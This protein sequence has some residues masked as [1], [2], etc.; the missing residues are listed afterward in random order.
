LHKE[1]LEETLVFIK[2]PDSVLD[3]IQKDRMDRILRKYREDFESV[4]T[5]YK[6]I[7]IDEKSGIKAQMHQITEKLEESFLL[8]YVELFN[9]IS[10][11][12]EFNERLMSIVTVIMIFILLIA[13]PRINY[14]IMNIITDFRLGLMD[15]FEYLNKQRDDTHHIKIRAKGEIANMA[16]MVNNQIDKIQDDIEKD[17]ELIKDTTQVAKQVS[18]GSISI[19]ISKSSNNEALNELKDVFNYMLESLENNIAQILHVV[20]TYSEHDY[21]KRVKNNNLQ[22]EMA[23]LVEGINTLGD[24]VSRMLVHNKQNG[25]VLGNSANELTNSVSKLSASVKHQADSFNSTSIAVEQITSSLHSTYS[26][27][28]QMYKISEDTKTN[29]QDGQRLTKE[30]V[31]AMDGINDSTNN[32]KVAIE[33][34]NQIAFQTNILSLNAAVEAATAGEAGKGFAVVAQEVRNLANRSADVA[35]EIKTLVDSA[36]LQAENG[37]KIAD[38]MLEG[39]EILYNNISTTTTLIEDVTKS[40]KEQLGAINKINDT[41]IE[42]DTATQDDAKVAMVTDKVAKDTSEI[43]KLIIFHVDNKEF[44]GKESI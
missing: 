29:S 19:R 33:A 9:E 41:I 8:S 18:Q 4:V 2:Q 16:D 42:L 31:S 11:R 36:A 14:D 24:A 3:D 6:S 38:E 27:A 23:T 1:V 39:F 25:I 34:I 43:A 21:R 5:A 12:V 32:I 35:N 28:E 40:S 10:Y 37:K 20:Q 15:F 17:K 13:I 22:D 26:K 44:S 30:T 7:G